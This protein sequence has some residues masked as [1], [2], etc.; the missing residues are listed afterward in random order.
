MTTR[1]WSSMRVKVNSL[2]KWQHSN[3]FDTGAG[4]DELKQFNKFIEMEGQLFEYVWK[5]ID[6]KEAVRIRMEI[7]VL[8]DY[9][10]DTQEYKTDDLM[11]SLERIRQQSIG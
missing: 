8:L 2:N 9:P 4:K 5:D 6:E 7:F 11:K 3:T 1:V 10:G